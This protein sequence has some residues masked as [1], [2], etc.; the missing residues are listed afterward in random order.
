M[1]NS[2]LLRTKQLYQLLDLEPFIIITALIFLAWVFYKL[3]LREAT[4]QRHKSL[5]ANFNSV[6]KHYLILIVFFSLYWLVYQNG[7]PDWSLGRSL[8]Y[9]ALLT[10]FWGILVFVKT[11]RLIILQYLF[12]GSMKSGVP[13]VIVN[14]FSLLISMVILLWSF[15]HLFGIQLGPLLATSAAFSIILGLALQDTLGNLFAGISLQLDKSFEIGDWLEVMI[16]SSKVVGQVNEITWRAT[17]LSGW[18]DE[19]ITIPNRTIANAQ[20]SNY[21]AGD[22][23][24]VR[25]QSFRFPYT[26]NSELVRETLVN[27]LQKVSRVRK[28]LNP[29]CYIS[30]NTDSW[31]TFKLVYYIDSYGAQ[32]VIGDQVTEKA[33]IALRDQNIEVGHQTIKVLQN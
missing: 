11:C 30:E 13:I 27:S 6:F 1:E 4:K 9:V 19:V 18:S 10:Y 28:D 23:P 2:P 16:G 5:Q 32:F 25:S 20:I 3:F 21:Q 8:P 7:N 17:L 14:L 26:V 33:L 24:I 29:I 12:L 22:V 31:V 15:S